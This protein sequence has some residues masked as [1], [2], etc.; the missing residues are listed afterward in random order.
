MDV[1]KRFVLILAAIVLLPMAL[2]VLL[3]LLVAFVACV[4]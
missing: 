4:S 2:K 1:L 3:I